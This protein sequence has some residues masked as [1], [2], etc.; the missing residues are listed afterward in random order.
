M[1]SR[2]LSADTKA[3]VK[4]HTRLDVEAIDLAKGR[5]EMPAAVPRLVQLV[6]PARV[7]LVDEVL[8][9]VGRRELSIT[10]DWPPIHLVHQLAYR[11]KRVHLRRVDSV[12]HDGRDP[13]RGAG[14]SAYDHGG[15]ELTRV[16]R[17][18][19]RG[20]GWVGHFQSRPLQGGRGPGPGAEPSRPARLLAGVHI[21]RSC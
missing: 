2:P 21:G 4:L 1:P 10:L 6:P 17:G 7:D 14:D 9:A 5:T 18:E 15:R 16:G 19:L 3:V 12:D 20:G 11:V 13:G 8:V